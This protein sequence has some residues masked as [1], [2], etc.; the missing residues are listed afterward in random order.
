MELSIESP[1]LLDFVH[2]CKIFVMDCKTMR[3]SCYLA[4]KNGNTK[5]QLLVIAHDFWANLPTNAE[6]AEI[7]HENMTFI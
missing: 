7:F 6:N 3:K 1:F 5:S 2:L 4:T